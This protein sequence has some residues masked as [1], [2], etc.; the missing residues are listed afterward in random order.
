MA[1]A[2]RATARSTSLSTRRCAKATAGRTTSDFVVDAIALELPVPARGP[3]AAPGGRAAGRRPA[4]ARAR[5]SLVRRAHARV[6]LAAGAKRDMALVEGASQAAL[7]PD[8]GF[9]VC[10][11]CGSAIQEVEDSE[12]GERRFLF[13]GE[14]PEDG[15][16]TVHTVCVRCQRQATAP[17]NCI[18]RSQKKRARDHE[19]L[20]SETV[21]DVALVVEC[22]IDC[23][24]CGA[25]KETTPNHGI[26]VDRADNVSL[27]RRYTCP[28]SQGVGVGVLQKEE[29]AAPSDASK[30]TAA[31]EEPTAQAAVPPASTCSRRTRNRRT[32]TWR[33][34]S[35]TSTIQWSSVRVRLR[36]RLRLRVRR[37][38][39]FKSY[40]KRPLRTNDYTVPA[41]V[42]RSAQPDGPGCL[43]ETF[44]TTPR[45]SGTPKSRIGL[46]CAFGNQDGA[47]RFCQRVVPGVAWPCPIGS[48]AAHE[49][50]DRVRLLAE[51]VGRAVAGGQKVLG[52]DAAASCVVGHDVDDAEVLCLAALYNTTRGAPP[53]C[54]RRC[55]AT[56]TAQPAARARPP[57]RNRP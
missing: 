43:T 39:H 52:V 38:G 47:L 36:L 27:K 56:A 45:R 54:C 24:L 29:A 41:A 9:F 15:R 11:D 3:Q 30:P 34:S 31:S 10:V 16:P 8:L 35:A 44:L 7:P 23:E 57:A 37:C 48:R 4:A 46:L 21:A 32:W 20:F 42:A 55:G 49:V 2:A 5:A 12:K 18:Y 25:N 22:E 28:T 1:L 19:P 17:N 26:I 14:D 33:R 51:E 13:H 53:T 50:A 40:S 6:A